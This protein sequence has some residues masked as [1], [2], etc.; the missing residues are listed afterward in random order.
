MSDDVPPSCAS[1]RA[2]MVCQSSRS[3]VSGRGEARGVSDRVEVQAAIAG[4]VAEI[5]EDV[6]QSRGV[7]VDVVGDHGDH[8]IGPPDG[9]VERVELGSAVRQLHRRS[10]AH[11]GAHRIVLTEIESGQSLR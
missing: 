6:A 11:V 5:G 1:G 7:I 9:V 10:G 2:A 4:P 3:R 8:V